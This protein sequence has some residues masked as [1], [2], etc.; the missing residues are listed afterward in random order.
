MEHEHLPAHTH[1]PKNPP[2]FLAHRLKNFKNLPPAIQKLC[3]QFQKPVIQQNN[4]K[5]E[6]NNKKYKN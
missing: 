5:N 4:N 6:F 2:L 3:F 1:I